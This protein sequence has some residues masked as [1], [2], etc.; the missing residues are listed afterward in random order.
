MPHNVK[1]TLKVVFFSREIRII[2]ITWK[3]YTNIQF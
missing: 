1:R 3:H 2:Y